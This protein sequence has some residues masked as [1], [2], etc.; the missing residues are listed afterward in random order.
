MTTQTQSILVVEDNPGVV[1][2]LRMML[3]D[4]GYQVLSAASVREAL[5]ILRTRP[6][7]LVLT[8]AFSP[9]PQSALDSVEPLIDAAGA[10]P[11]ALMTGHQVSREEA[12]ARGYCAVIDKP[13]DYDTLLDQIRGCLA[14]SDVAA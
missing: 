3:E 6:V 5:E 2:V 12:G 11:V 10:T 7:D 13:F 8:D 14:G 1:L 9:T 4:E